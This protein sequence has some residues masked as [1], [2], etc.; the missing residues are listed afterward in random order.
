M[1]H[2]LPRQAADFLK[3]E[4]DALFVDCRSDAEFFFVGHALGSVLVP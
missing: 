1:Q 2:L 4:P 3:H